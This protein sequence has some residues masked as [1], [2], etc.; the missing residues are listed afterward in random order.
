MIDSVA[1]FHVINCSN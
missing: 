1:K